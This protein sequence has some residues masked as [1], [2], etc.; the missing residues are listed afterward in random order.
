MNDPVW[1]EA[2]RR[3]QASSPD[4][5]SPSAAGIVRVDS[6]PSAWQ[7]MQ[8]VLFIRRRQISWVTSLGMFV[9]PPKSFAGGIFS[10][11]YQ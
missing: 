6:C 1:P 5:N 11:E 9:V 10:I 2:T 4:L 7:P 8:S 3:A